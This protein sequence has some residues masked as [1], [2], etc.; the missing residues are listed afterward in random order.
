M[1]DKLNEA[2]FIRDHYSVRYILNAFKVLKINYDGYLPRLKKVDL[3]D[4][5]Y[6]NNI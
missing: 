3:R 1:S 2:L 4:M 5:I 6:Q